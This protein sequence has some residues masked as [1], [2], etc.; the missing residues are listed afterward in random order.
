MDVAINVEVRYHLA[1]APQGSSVPSA[2]FWLGYRK[3]E[4]LHFVDLKVQLK[5]Y[6]D[7]LEAMHFAS[8]PECNLA[9]G[10]AIGGFHQWLNDWAVDSNK[11]L[12]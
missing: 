12:H 5:K 4:D 10:K 7:S 8:E 11:R 3:H 9:C 2:A 6:A 1:G